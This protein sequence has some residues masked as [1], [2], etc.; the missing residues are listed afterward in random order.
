MHFENLNLR[1]G[2]INAVKDHSN[3]DRLYVISV[4]LGKI[5]RDLQIVSGIREFYT[6]EELL[7]K[8][9]IVLVNLE[10]AVFRGIESNGMLLAADFSGD[11][12][13][14]TANGSS[15]GDRVFIE[16]MNLDSEEEKITFEDWKKIKLTT[17][18]NKVKLDNLFLKTDNEEVITDK[19]VSDGCNIQ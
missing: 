8:N 6:K 13:L 3:A 11:I 10:S 19:E 5:S 18:N 9:I 4:D 1:V 7:G 2:K 16:N 17:L 14:L 12:S 15:Q